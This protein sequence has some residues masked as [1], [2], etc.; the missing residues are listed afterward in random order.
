MSFSAQVDG[1]FA[2][3]AMLA[4][5]TS[6]FGLLA[7]VLASVGLYGVTAYSVERRTSEIGIRM[8]LGADRMNVLKLVLRAAFVQIGIGLAIG[9]PASILAGYAMTT[10]LFGVKPYAPDILLV[11]TAVLSLAAVFATVLPGRKAATLEP[12]R[13]LRTE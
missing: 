2:Q 11:T 5:L 13:A 3:N 8:A 7:L 1:N 10:Q 4:K 6:L 12:I 9:I